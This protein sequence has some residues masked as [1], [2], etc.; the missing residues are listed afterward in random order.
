MKMLVSSDIILHPPNLAHCIVCERT[1]AS[2]SVERISNHLPVPIL[3]YRPSPC[4]LYCVQ[5]NLIERIE[6][7]LSSPIL[8]YRPSPSPPIGPSPHFV[9][10]ALHTRRH[11]R[12][13]THNKQSAPT[14]QCSSAPQ[15]LVGEHVSFLG[16]EQAWEI[17]QVW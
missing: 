12:R 17:R 10:G 2:R 13:T 8:H 11:T 16:N 14:Q 7:L 9:S 15:Q 6:S 3:Y 1:Y 4:P 5:A